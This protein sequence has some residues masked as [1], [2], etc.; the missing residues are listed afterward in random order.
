MSFLY[1]TEAKHRRTGTAYE[2]IDMSCRSNSAVRTRNQVMCHI[3]SHCFT[4]LFSG[5]GVL[6]KGGTTRPQITHRHVSLDAAGPVW[7][8]VRPLTSLRRTFLDPMKPAN[9]TPPWNAGYAI[10][11]LGMEWSTAPPSPGVLRVFSRRLGR[12]RPNPKQGTGIK[13]PI[14]FWRGEVGGLIFSHTPRGLRV[15]HLRTFSPWGL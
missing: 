14:S 8:P 2:M 7:G 15:S 11:L 6:S 13:K 1:F 4:I 10:K 3:V 12:R 5:S 9:I